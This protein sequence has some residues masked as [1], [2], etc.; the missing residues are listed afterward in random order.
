MGAYRL[1]IKA[2]AAKELSRLGS[3]ADRRRIVQ[4]ISTLADDLRPHGAEK[5]AGYDDRYRIRQGSY[6]VVYLID[7]KRKEVTVFKVGDRKD[8]YK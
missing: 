1:L 8:V 5:L 7:D 3:K 4:R 2:S 6:R